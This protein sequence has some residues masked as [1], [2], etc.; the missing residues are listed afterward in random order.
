VRLVFESGRALAHVA[1]NLGVHRETL[2][3]WVR[4]AEAD[5][6]NAW[7]TSASPPP[8]ARSPRPTTTPWPSFVSTLKTELIQGR[9]FATRFGAHVRVR[10]RV[11]ATR[12]GAQVR[13]RPSR[14]S[15][16]AIGSNSGRRRPRNR[17]TAPPSGRKRAQRARRRTVVR[18]HGASS[19]PAMTRPPTPRSPSSNTSAGSTT[20][21]CT[22][23]SATF[24]QPNSSSTPRRTRRSHPH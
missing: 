22:G 8:S 6:R 20:P 15:S 10:H 19:G 4:Q 17:R 24:R 18:T 23:P 11:F 2:R 21:A 7:P 1:R 12:F 5:T 9:V 3:L 14:V 13:V 16:R